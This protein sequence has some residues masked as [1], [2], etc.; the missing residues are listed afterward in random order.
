MIW[1]YDNIQC[2]LTKLR[3]CHGQMVGELDE[4]LSEQGMNDCLKKDIDKLEMMN[5]QIDVLSRY[6][7]EGDIIVDGVLPSFT[8]HLTSAANG[9]VFIMEVDGEEVVQITNGPD[10]AETFAEN[11]AALINNETE[12]NGGFT[13]VYVEEPVNSTTVT[14]YA[15]EG[16]GAE[17]NGTPVTFQLSPITFVQVYGEEMYFQGGITEVVAGEPCITDAQAREVYENIK[18]NCVACDSDVYYTDN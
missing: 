11:I 14:V 12:T 5:Y 15:P 4:K 1:D 17:Y 3:C 9:Y 6:A 8:F 13:A 16:S 7:P 2:E 18:T 10:S